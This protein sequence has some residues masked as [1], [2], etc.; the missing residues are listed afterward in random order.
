MEQ[1]LPFIE[2][3]V[4]YRLHNRLPM[5][6]TISWMNPVHIH[7]HMH[8]ICPVHLSFDLMPSNNPR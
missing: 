8:A 6:R 1:S 7:C 2:P 5:D 3:E 4:Y